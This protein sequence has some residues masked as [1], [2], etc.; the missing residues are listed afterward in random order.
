MSIKVIVSMDVK[1]FDSFSKVFNSEGP[2]NARKEVGLIAEAHRNL[3]NPTNAVIIGT[4]PSKE[5][6]LGFLT[7]P[8][9]ADRM[10]SAGVVSK[11]TVTFLEN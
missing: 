6:F 4:A 1:D 5:A 3:D 10:K 11:P 8:E 9:Q 7:T 2:K